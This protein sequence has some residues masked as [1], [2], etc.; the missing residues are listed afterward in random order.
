MAVKFPLVLSTLVAALLTISSVVGLI[1]GQRGLY[2]PDP[3]TLPTFIGQDAITL[4]VGLPLLLGSMW[5]TSRGSLRDLLVW[6]GALVYVA[7]SY[8]H[9]LISPEF[10]VLYLGYIV[11]VSVSGYCLLYLLLGIDAPA[12]R[13]QFSSGTPVR[14]VG[15]FLALM[16][17]LMTFKWVSGIVLAL[18]TDTLPAAKDLG[19]WPMDLVVAFPA[20]FWGG[21]WLWRRQAPPAIVPIRCLRVSSRRPPFATSVRRECCQLGGARSTER[22]T[23]HQVDSHRLGFD[24]PPF[25]LT[26]GNLVFTS[27][28]RWRQSTTAQCVCTEETHATSTRSGSRY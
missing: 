9:Y 21:M 26:R 24:P 28:N 18:S 6:L 20:M 16:P 23:R 27:I 2:R 22:Y 15:G 13:S 5:L 11:I 1:F 4:L 14:L 17:S 25:A 19:V 8:A 10:N 12:V 3:G 7:Y